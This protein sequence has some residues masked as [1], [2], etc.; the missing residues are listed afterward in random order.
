MH[1]FKSILTKITQLTFIDSL[2]LFSKRFCY[3]IGGLVQN[4]L[5]FCHGVGVS[6]GWISWFWHCP[7]STSNWRY[8]THSDTFLFL[9]ISKIYFVFYQRKTKNGHLVKNMTRI[10]WWEMRIHFTRIWLGSVENLSRIWRESGENLARIWRESGENLTY[11]NFKVVKWSE[12]M[13]N[14]PLW[15]AVVWLA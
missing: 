13:W 6:R 10:F 12:K 3:S 7:S 15:L 8:C 4:G 9:F 1:N 2:S 11:R 5:C 14:I